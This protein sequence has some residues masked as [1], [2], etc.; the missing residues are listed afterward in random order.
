MKATATLKSW[1]GRRLLSASSATSSG[2]SGFNVVPRNMRMPLERDGVD[3]KPQ[4]GVMRS[5][6]PIK[7][8]R[9]LFGIN[10][11]LV[12]GYD[13][14]KDVLGDTASYST[15]IRPMLGM[16]AGVTI[17]GLGFTD[18]PEHTRLR[19]VLTP[20]FTMRSL[21]R[22]QPTID[23]IVAERLDALAAQDGP[24][25][26][27]TE[28]AFPIP[29]MVI[30]EL[31]GLD[32][33]DR[34]VFRTLGHARFDV[35]G[36]GAGTF[37]A[38]SESRTFLQGVV[39]AQRS[40]PGP[41]LLGQ[42][43]RD[44]GDEFSDDELAGLA[45]GVFIGGYETS[46]SM[47]SLGALTLL[48]DRETF[49]RAAGEDVDDIVEEMLRYLSVVQIA[50]PRFAKQDMTLHG[51]SIKKGDAL[52]CSLIGADRDPVLGAHV[53]RLDPAKAGRSHLAFGHGFHRCV[54]A[55]LARMELRSAFRAMA[56]RYPDMQLAVPVDDLEFRK[57][58]IVFGLDSL[59]VIPQ[60]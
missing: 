60:P 17:G 9:R 34:E 59:P 7:R 30:C 22:L 58:S 26:L 55:E 43:V 35:L 39:A 5:Q 19:R 49:H 53:D 46:A 36:G 15:D 23:R 44:H 50:F 24:V 13:A 48:R 2:L 11:F 29:V 41:G 25:D 56:T 33:A 12:S 6:T 27:V 16:G 31:L 38:M 51:V 21:Q 20:Q 45:D 18:P 57:L 47:L 52:V 14:V 28:F 1:A 10:V 32:V 37:G 40:N 42:L 4:L 3:P 54:G 8:L